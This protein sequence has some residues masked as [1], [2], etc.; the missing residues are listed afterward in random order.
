MRTR[1]SPFPRRVELDLLD[2]ERL[3]EL[4]Q[5][6][7][8]HLTAGIATEQ[9]GRFPRVALSDVERR[10]VEAIEGKRDELVALAST[11][12][13]FDTTARNPGDPPRQER[14]LQEY[15]AE[16]AAAGRSRG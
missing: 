8:P 2:D 5:D 12:V 4:V 14:E 3:M 16:P 7:R 9:R 15:L 1:I 10:A 6:C 13:G 11:L